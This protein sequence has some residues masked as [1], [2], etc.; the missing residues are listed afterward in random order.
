MNRWAY[1]KQALVGGCVADGVVCPKP[2]KIGVALHFHEPTRPSSRLLHI[3]NQQSEACEAKAGMELLDIIRMTESC[4]FGRSNFQVASSPPFS[5]DHHRVGPLT[6]SSKMSSFA[7]TTATLY[8]LC[9][10]HHHP[11]VK[12]E[13]VSG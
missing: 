6:P 2:R 8:L 9:L 5:L 3:N 1:Q 7:T 13:V 4:G 10:K 11:P 12:E